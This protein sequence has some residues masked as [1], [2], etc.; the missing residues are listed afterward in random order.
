[1]AEAA[2]AELARLVREVGVRADAVSGPAPAP[3]YRVRSRYRWHLLVR[4]PDAVKLHARVQDAA[5]RL[6]AAPAGRGI[7]LDLD[8]DPASVC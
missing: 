3:R 7:R 6:R 2:A 4:G 5:R 1:V 8:V